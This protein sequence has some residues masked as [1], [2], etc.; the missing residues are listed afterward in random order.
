MTL[1]NDDP[2]VTERVTSGRRGPLAVALVALTV[3]G[4]LIWKPWDRPTGAT[5]SSNP[6]IP[7]PTQIVA[8]VPVTPP[9]SPAPNPTLRPTPAPT[10]TPI[11]T[12]QPGY[13]IAMRLIPSAGAIVRCS[14]E[15]DTDGMTNVLSSMFIGETFLHAGPGTVEVDIRRV[16]WRA[17]VQ[18]NRLETLFSANWESVGE[19]RRRTARPR[20]GED[21]VF[22]G[23]AI[24]YRNL[25][26][27]T[28]MVARLVVRMKWFGPA[29]TL[30]GSDEA[31][32]PVYS[33]GGSLL[34][35]GCHVFTEMPV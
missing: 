20:A 3:I 35:E 13:G 25:P 29:Q 19:S 1:Q 15:P 32:V 8:H 6:S 5:P 22:A 28:T 27:G 30:L 31:V 33:A 2:L 18:V 12:L 4:L 10:P 14:Y 11:P 17:I 16:T 21:V 23:T 26:S 9:I 34:V 24:H 7:S